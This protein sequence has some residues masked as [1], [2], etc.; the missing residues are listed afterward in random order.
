MVTQLSTIHKS[1][2]STVYDGDLQSKAS[3]QLLFAIPGF[4]FGSYLD[5]Q[6]LQF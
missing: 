6:E 2:K 5:R 3:F 4:I 1:Y